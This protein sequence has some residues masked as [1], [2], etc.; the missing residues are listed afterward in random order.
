MKLL[1]IC[2]HVYDW[3]ERNGGPSC[4]ACHSARVQRAI[5]VGAPRIVGT[6]SGPFVETKALEAIAVD[7]T[8]KETA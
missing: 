5:G 4:P 2:D 8:V 6:A 7:L 3:Q 1:C